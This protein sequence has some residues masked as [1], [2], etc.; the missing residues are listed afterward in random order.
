MLR[1]LY[2]YSDLLRQH[3]R[4]QEMAHDQATSARGEDLAHR[5]LQRHGMVVVARNYRMSSGAGELDLIAWER[6]T[7]V[8]IEVKSRETG[9]YGSPDRAIGSEKQ[10]SLLR[11]GR[12]YARH[13]GVKWDHVRFDVVTVIFSAPPKIE[14]QRNALS[15]RGT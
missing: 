8:F 10:K 5:F 13:A 2:R 15:A 11:A 12:E 6:E 1:T 3:S 7:L 4:E 9:D 14:H